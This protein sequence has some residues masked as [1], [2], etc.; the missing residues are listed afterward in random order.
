M[1]RRPPRSNRTDTPF[2]YTP[3]FRSPAR[4][5]DVSRLRGLGSTG[6]PLP[7]EAYDWIYRHVR[8]DIWL[9]PMSGGTDFAGSF[10]AGCPLLPVYS[11]EMQCRC[12]EIGRAHV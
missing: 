3:L 6:S 9:V 11:G 1:L 10:V 12:L 2:P 7:V 8:E 4:I 5:A